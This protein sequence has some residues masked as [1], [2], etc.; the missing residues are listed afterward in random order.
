MWPVDH[1]VGEEEVLADAIHHMRTH[2]LSTAPV[3]RTGGRLEG[4]LVLREAL[5]ATATGT[6]ASLARGDAAVRADDDPAAAR[7]TML[8][9]SVNRLPVVDNGEVVG[10]VSQGDLR[11]L[12]LL[13]DLGIPP[14]R[15]SR[16]ISPRDRMSERAAASYLF[17]AVQAVHL[18]EQ[19]RS[20]DAPLVRR[21]L[22]LGCGHG[23]VL[24]VLRARYPDA[25]AVACDIDPDAVAF[26]AAEFGATPVVIAPGPQPPNLEGPFEL[27]WSGSVLTHLDEPRWDPLLVA[28]RDALAAGGRAIVTVNGPAI[29]E[30]WSARNWKMDPEGEAFEALL[31]GYR[32]HG[33]GYSPYPNQEAYGLSLCTPERVAEI[34][35]RAGL[36]VEQ[37][38]P[39]AWTATRLGQDVVVLA[40]H[41]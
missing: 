35:A 3:R 13:A 33:F 30:L 10:V 22:D 7:Q 40:A 36:R 17:G 21:L 27:I 9:Q 38:L 1:A 25:E 8:R 37:V 4:T 2:A 12:A 19:C 20:P 24:R 28:L 23:R 6:V 31:G 5:Q 26:C 15:V 16:R 29:A 34:A 39:S 11:A 18:I 41:D 14:G 32:E